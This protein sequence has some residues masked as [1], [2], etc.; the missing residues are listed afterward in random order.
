MVSSLYN[1]DAKTEVK[2]LRSEVQ[3]L[4][5]EL[6]KMKRTFEDILYNLDTDNFCSRFVKEQNDMRTA[7]EVT[8]EGIKST[9]SKGD[10]EKYSTITQTA[11]SIQNIVSQLVTLG[12]AIPITSLDKATDKSKIYVIQEKNESGKVTSETYY[13]FNEISNKWEVLSGESLYTIFKQTA[14]GFLLRGNVL[15]DGSCILTDTLTFN[16]EAKPIEV[17][18]STD[19][20]NNWHYTFD[21]ANDKFMRI[22]IGAEWTSAIKVVGDDGEDGQDGTNANVTFAKVNSVL[23]NLF[24]TVSGG[25]P[26]QVDGSYIYSPSVLGGEFYGGAYY[27]GIGKGYSS[28]DED[29]FTVNDNDGY[30]K[31]ALGYDADDY[32]YPYVILGA[33]TGYTSNGAAIVYK[34]GNGIWIGDSSVMRYPGNCPGGGSSAGTVNTILPHAT[35]IFIDFAED[36]VYVYRNGYCEVCGS[37]SGSGGTNYAEF[38]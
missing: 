33:G 27:A 34:M 28:M 4:R 11:E 10:M 35:G 6:A 21:S 24:K 2:R 36:E 7:I 29:G 32:T 1:S 30:T 38:K 12:E 3:V 26:T 31:I 15:V 14:E 20:T 18:Y 17:Q 19:G 13:Y 8:A 9:V 37:G 16:S 22:K 23:G 25:T 5:D